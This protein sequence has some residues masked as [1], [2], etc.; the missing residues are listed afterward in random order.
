MIKLAR[1]ASSRLKGI[2]KG[3]MPAG[4]T[5]RFQ[6]TA[7]MCQKPV[8]Q[9]RNGVCIRLNFLEIIKMAMANISDHKPHMA[10]FNGS[11]GKTRPMPL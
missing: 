2:A 11:D 7:Y 10:P 5:L 1:K 9:A 3:R 4:R 8:N 6:T